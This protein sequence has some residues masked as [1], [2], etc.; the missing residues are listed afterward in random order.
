MS[1]TLSM[2]MSRYHEIPEWAIEGV[3]ELERIM[4]ARRCAVRATM[5]SVEVREIEAREVFAK[6]LGWMY[7]EA[8]DMAEKGIDIRKVEVPEILERAVEAGLIHE[9][10]KP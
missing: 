8:C 1:E 5:T 4:A 6:A 10:E 7:A 3:R 2:A 9:R